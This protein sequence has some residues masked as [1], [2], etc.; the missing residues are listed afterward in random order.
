VKRPD[1]GKLFRPGATG[2]ARVL[3]ELEAAVMEVVWSEP[4][5]EWTA[6]EVSG[7]V[8]PQR[9]VKHI[10]VVTV[11]NNLW[12]KGLL[13]RRKRQGVLRYG[14]AVDRQEFLAS[15]SREVAEGML[16]LAPE[17]AVTSFVDAV[18]RTGPEAL[19]ELRRLIAEHED[20]DR[21]RKVDES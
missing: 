7:Q 9:D 4:D 12:R 20:R 13:R 17:I 8:G 10:T 16:E 3:G 19:D 15:V 1:L 2:L 6:R 5:K 11:L 18:S 14:G 21:K